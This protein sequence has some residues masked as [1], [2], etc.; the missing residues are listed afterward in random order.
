[1]IILMILNM[2]LG[3]T[4]SLCYCRIS[5]PL[6]PMCAT[7]VL[8][9]LI[10]FFTDKSTDT[11]NNNNNNHHDCNIYTNNYKLYFQIKYFSLHPPYNNN[12]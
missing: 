11:K 4:S 12:L 8:P 9:S 5:L 3:K 1:M 7:D 10:E 2:S 6:Y